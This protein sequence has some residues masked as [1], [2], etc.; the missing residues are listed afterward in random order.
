MLAENFAGKFLNLAERDC[1]KTTRAFKAKAETADAA[2]QI[3]DAQLSHGTH[4]RF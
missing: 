2:E 3:E 4:S 1:F